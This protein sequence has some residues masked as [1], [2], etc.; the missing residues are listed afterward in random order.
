MVVNIRDRTDSNLSV[1]TGPAHQYIPDESPPTPE[2]ATWGEQ[3]GKQSLIPKKWD[4]T[5]SSNKPIPLPMMLKG[6][7][8]PNM[9]E[10]AQTFE[11]GKV[12][13]FAVYDDEDLCKLL[14]FQ[15]AWAPVDLLIIRFGALRSLAIGGRSESMSSVYGPP[16]MMQKSASFGANGTPTPTTPY[17]SSPTLVG[18][19]YGSTTSFMSNQPTAPNSFHRY[20]VSSSPQSASHPDLPSIYDASAPSTNSVPTAPTS[21]NKS[22]SGSMSWFFR[23]ARSPSFSSDDTSKTP[24]PITPNMPRPSVGANPLRALLDRR[25]KYIVLELDL[26]DLYKRYDEKARMGSSFTHYVLEYIITHLKSVPVHSLPKVTGF[27]L[28]GLKELA[29][30]RDRPDAGVPKILDA[31]KGLSSTSTTTTTSDSPAEK[32]SSQISLTHVSTSKPQWCSPIVLLD[33]HATT[34]YDTLRD[35]MNGILLQNPY[36]K[37][38]GKQKLRFGVDRSDFDA[39]C[40]KLSVEIS[41]RDDF[42]ILERELL[43]CRLDAVDAAVVRSYVRWFRGLGFVGFWSQDHPMGGHHSAASS[44]T[45]LHQMQQGPNSMVPPS[46]E[47]VKPVGF[48]DLGDDSI[49]EMATHP[50]I[51]KVRDDV[52]TL[53]GVIIDQDKREEDKVVNGIHMAETVTQEVWT[54]ILNPA[55]TKIPHKLLKAL[56][57]PMGMPVIEIGRGAPAQVML[58]KPREPVAQTVSEMWRGVEHLQKLL[59]RHRNAQGQLQPYALKGIPNASQYSIDSSMP[60][61]MIMKNPSMGVST[62]A[63]SRSSMSFDQRSM[64]TNVQL[65]RTNTQKSAGGWSEKSTIAPTVTTAPTNNKRMSKR[66]SYMSDLQPPTINQGGKSDNRSRAASNLSA[67]PGAANSGYA[68]HILLSSVTHFTADYGPQRRDEIAHQILG[69]MFDLL[70][71]KL[72]AEADR[73]VDV[74]GAKSDILG[75]VLEILE[76]MVT[77]PSPRVKWLLS[78]SREAT[79]IDGAPESYDPLL[80]P[81]MHLLRALL[82]GLKTGEIKIHIPMKAA[83]LANLKTGVAY[84]PVWCV[85]GERHGVTHFFLSEEL[86]VQERVEVLL[87]GW[88][89]AREGWSGVRCIVAEGLVDAQRDSKT[90]GEEE[91][92][93]GYRLP[94]PRRLEYEIKALCYSELLSTIR[95]CDGK[96]KSIWGNPALSEG[97]ATYVVGVCDYLSTLSEWL[98]TEKEGW[99]DAMKKSA[100]EGYEPRNPVEMRVSQWVGRSTLSPRGGDELLEVA[101]GIADSISALLPQL[102]EQKVDLS[103]LVDENRLTFTEGKRRRLWAYCYLFSIFWKSC[104]RTAYT[105]LLVSLISKNPSFLP[106]ADQA[107]VCIEMTTTSSILQALFSM[108]SHSLSRSLHALLRKRTAEER[109][110]ARRVEKHGVEDLKEDGVEEGSQA[111]KRSVVNAYIFVYPILLDIAMVLALGSGIF[112]SNRMDA[113]GLEASS[114]VFLGM[115]PVIGAVMNSVGRTVTYYFYQKSIPLMIAAFFRRLAGAIVLFLI[116]GL[117]MGGA[118]WYMVGSWVHGLL[119]MIYA[120]MFG[121]FMVFFCVLIILRDPDEYFYKSAGPAAVLRMLIILLPNA[122]ICRFYFQGP[123]HP[124]IVWGIYILSLTLATAYMWYS[125]VWIAQTYIRWPEEVKPTPRKEILEMYEKIAP[126]PTAADEPDEDKLGKKTRLWERSATEWYSDK[127]ER[128]LGEIAKPGAGN[129]NEPAIQKRMKQWFWENM[130]MKWYA[131]RAGMTNL[132]KFSSEWDGVVKQAVAELKKK[133]TVEKLNRGDILFDNELPAIAFGFLYFVMIFGDRWT[134]L[135]V[136]GRAVTFFPSSDVGSDYLYGALASLL[137]LLLSSGLLELTL[138]SFYANHK[139]IAMTSLADTEGPQTIFEQYR[140][141]LKVLYERELKKFFLCS[142]PLLVIGCAV[143]VPLSVLNKRWTMLI[144]FGIT[145]FGYIGLLIGLF[146]K[147]FIAQKESTV[148][149]GLGFSLLIG[150]AASTAVVKL[151][152]EPQ[153]ACIATAL[154]G[155]GFAAVCV[156]SSYFEKVQSVHYTISISPQLTSSGQRNIGQPHS[157]AIANARTTLGKNLLDS[158][159]HTERV[160]ATSALGLGVKAYLQ[161]TAE[162]LASLQPTHIFRVAFASAPMQFMNLVRAFMENHLQA[163][164]AEEALEAGGA[165]YAAIAMADDRETNARRLHVFLSPIEAAMSQFQTLLVTVEALVHEFVEVT[166]TLHS[167]ACIAETLLAVSGPDGGVVREGAEDWA[168]RLLPERIKLQIEAMNE[169]D[170]AKVWYR[171]QEV[172]GKK[173]SLGIDVDTKWHYEGG[174]TPEDRTFMVALAKIWWDAFEEMELTARYPRAMTSLLSRAPASFRKLLT[175]PGQPLD[176]DAHGAQSLLSCAL[177]FNIEHLCKQAVRKPG[178]FD[179]GTSSRRTKR[180]FGSTLTRKLTI[181]RGFTLSRGFTISRTLSRNKAA[182]RPKLPNDPKEHKDSKWDRLV[183]QFLETRVV[184]FLALT[185]DQRFGREVSSQYVL[186]LPLVVV[187]A[188]CRAL[189]NALQDSLLYK[190]NENI[191]LLLKQAKQGLCRVHHFTRGAGGRSE[192]SCVETYYSAS[193]TIVAVVDREDHGDVEAGRKKGQLT[194]NRYKISGPKPATWKAGNAKPVSTGCYE[195]LGVGR[196]RLLWEQ[197][198]D[199]GGKC[200]GTHIYEYAQGQNVI[201]RRRYVLNE[202]VDPAHYAFGQPGHPEPAEIQTFSLLADNAVVTEVVMIRKHKPSGIKST[203]HAAYEYPRKG[204][205]AGPRRAIFRS[206]YPVQWQMTVEYARLTRTEGKPR[207]ANVELVQMQGQSDVRYFTAFD[208]THPEHVRLDTV[209]FFM[210][211]TQPDVRVRTPN[212]IENDEFGILSEQ[213]PATL[214]ESSD[215]FVDGLR[216][217]SRRAHSYKPPFVQ[218]QRIEYHDTPYTSLRK[219]E[220]LWAG[221]RRGEIPGT[222]ARDLDE[223]FL[224]DEPLLGSYWRRRDVGDVE[225]ARRVLRERRQELTAELQMTDG[226]WTRTHLQIRY[227]DLYKLALGGDAQK[228]YADGPTLSKSQVDINDNGQGGT[229]NVTNVDSGTWPTS[230]GGVGSCRRDLIAGLNRVRWTAIAEIASAEMVQK[231]YPVEKHINAI[232]YLPLWDVDFGTPN[233]NVYR[234]VPHRLLQMK[235]RRTTAKVVRTMFVPLVQKLIKGCLTTDWDANSVD[236]YANV[237]VD[238]YKFFAVYDWVKAWNH[239]STQEAW[240]R[241]WLDIAWR[242]WKNE[243]LVDIETPTLRHVEMLYDLLARLL[244]PLTV[245]IPQDPVIH[246]SHHGVQAIVGV[247]AKALHGSSVV[248]WDHGILWRERLF[249]L[250]FDENMPRFVH[251]GFAG[252][253]RLVAK[254]VYARADY[255]TPCTSVQNVAWEAWLGGGK[256][257]NAYENSMMHRKIN[258]VL[259]GMDVMKFAP[260]PNLETDFPMGVMLSHISPVKDVMNAIAAAR[261]IVHEFKL[262]NYQLHIYGSPDKDP[263]YTAECQRAIANFGLANNVFMKGLGSPSKVLPTGWVFV[264]SSITE[265]LPLALGEAGLCGLPVVCTDVGG[266]REVIRIESTGETCGAIVPPSKPRQLAIAQLKVLAVSDGIGKF[267]GVDDAGGVG[268]DSFDSLVARGKLEERIC[269]ERVKGLRRKVGM[270][271]RE[272]TISVFSIARYWREHEQICWLGPAYAKK[273]R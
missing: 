245:T 35:K 127:M 234:T 249:G 18:S 172:V 206:N 246:C 92:I 116:C 88:C 196:R 83:F 256:H 251:I 74:E 272:R 248:V 125:F 122:F 93:D 71:K 158:L 179:G 200:I 22:R 51:L 227:S 265:G 149:G 108:S 17:A 109:Y 23:N 168:E 264:N 82:S 100:D 160:K 271:L 106:D 258:P 150:L 53:V 5:F 177:A 165:T 233:E 90:V 15:D 136:T 193:H 58:R 220:N 224:R 114:I 4:I 169:Q 170:K 235:A 225:G 105:E 266:S 25:T 38:N 60:M 221:W 199:A 28:T 91:R 155:W 203:I 191:N 156:G 40:K 213:T 140:L 98:L 147:L 137:Y 67:Y 48:T 162:T 226:P 111:L 65:Q 134:V 119:A 3:T 11:S 16:P 204:A 173:A 130:L 20:N 72:L 197:I 87:S 178:R 146:H 210:N 30:L 164:K 32:A 219:R 19:S 101:K 131:Q 228:V 242:Q 33:E 241:G 64:S 76:E 212:F 2:P 24:S 120:I 69:V 81:T 66:I 205:Q 55:T 133:Y 231:D 13:N 238:F 176:I 218:L 63:L 124:L 99:I 36:F 79:D 96:Q 103:V 240:I 12:R 255:V 62:A 151:V 163:H 6:A 42:V 268:D 180:G 252:L 117:I 54:D 214:Y 139:D 77:N 107:A 152:G 118:A 113:K 253:T 273:R 126:K 250:C 171:T 215:F 47:A 181:G 159:H 185:A 29:K 73:N 102:D 141:A 153:W 84:T 70:D 115:F 97:E 39:L 56:G 270:R 184:F 44:A 198:N 257:G 89:S 8:G 208:Y 237:F 112:S 104:R 61:P 195:Q 144:T 34:L 207:L 121:L 222:F 138:S 192:V 267:V 262:S 217:V 1:Y 80:S 211:D 27:Y 7:G 68:S 259:N 244:L 190:Q 75:S 143:I 201:P 247:V 189:L 263:A 236:E 57:E 157:E 154:C 37:S 188:V 123:S 129:H 145:T 232:I 46:V 59:P 110:A 254:V 260:N 85:V 148:N 182:S 50:S 45:S 194:V 187:H 49:F 186:R 86:G 216:A 14:T 229:L 78:L 52:Q 43:S 230:G 10:N 94:M 135:F 167:G 223:I 269:D 31:I 261:F 161:N 95:N 243:S 166:G 41:L 239:L 9:F 183:E 175:Q 128:A 132:K 26:A 202:E 142:F 21:S 209:R 174:M